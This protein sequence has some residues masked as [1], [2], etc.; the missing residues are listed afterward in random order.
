MDLKAHLKFVDEKA[1]DVIRNEEVDGREERF[2]VT[3]IQIQSWRQY[4]MDKVNEYGK[5]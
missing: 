1:E 4:I 3:A 2:E 5:E